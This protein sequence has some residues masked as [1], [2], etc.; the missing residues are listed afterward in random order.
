MKLYKKYFVIIASLVLLISLSLGTASYFIS[1]SIIIDKFSESS[2]ESLNYLLDITNNEMD[3]LEELF[4]VISSYGPLIKRISTDY[5]TTSEYQK[6]QD[7]QLVSDFLVH[8]DADALFHSVKLIYIQGNN[9][10][11]FW[12]GTSKDFMDVDPVI[13]IFD[14]EVH[15][16]GHLYYLGFNNSRNMFRRKS[17]SLQFVRTVVDIKGFVIGKM[18]FELEEEYISNLLQRDEVLSGTEVTLID[19]DGYIISSLRDEEIGSL[20]KEN[21]L[22][23]IKLDAYLD[24][25]GWQII[26]ETPKSYITEDQFEILQVTLFATVVSVLVAM[27]IITLIVRQLIKPIKDLTLAMGEVIE[28]D[29]SVRVHLKQKDE[30][31][32]LADQFN[33]MAMK[34]NENIEKELAYNKAINDADYRALQAQINPH[35]MYNALNTVKWI[36]SLQGSD[37]IIEIVNHLWKLLKLTSSLDGQIISLE[38]ELKVIDSYVRIQQARYNGKFQVLYNIDGEHLEYKIPKYILQPIVENAIFHGI[39]P[40]DG[41]GEVHIISSIIGKDIVI[42][43][44]DD[45][46][47]AD[48]NKMNKLL[49]EDT[50]L[51]HSSG[52]NNIGIKNVNDR[53]ILL[54]GRGYELT[55]HTTKGKGTN[56]EIRIPINEEI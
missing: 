52:L 46:V 56:V 50:D 3:Q 37:S 9:D 48:T 27:L 10:E 12:Y 32:D 43:V 22:D 19:T 8:L 33:I 35:F 25:F 2:Q 16:K 18:Y 31:G 47:G 51:S 21:R 38:D 28:G 14:D 44:K 6:M 23:T 24:N 36:A 7:D 53:L 45:G 34:V 54:Y 41:Q 29:Y 55:F 49:H 11:E 20:Y 40:K 42:K 4:E 1:R 13:S 26:R 5:E 15:S 39:E 30:I 17:K